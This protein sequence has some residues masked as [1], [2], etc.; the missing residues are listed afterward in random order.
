MVDCFLMVNRPLSLC[1]FYVL[2]QDNG[3]PIHPQSV[4]RW[5]ERFCA[6]NDLPK[7]SLHKL[8]HTSASI[9]IESGASITTVSQRLGH[10]QISTTLD[11]YSHQIKKRDAA[12]AED[13]GK[14][15][16]LKKD[17]KKNQIVR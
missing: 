5:F 10:S 1:M 17:T 16:Y 13:L 9:L 2:I 4:S 15:L 7:I 3:E 11:V 6:R 14:V 8:R 12:A